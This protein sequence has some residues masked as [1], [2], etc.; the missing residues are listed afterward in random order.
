M[1]VH[2]WDPQS[3][4]ELSETAL[5]R[6]LE[7]QGYSVTRYVYPPGTHFPEHTHGVDKIDAVV[8]GRFE[9]IVAGTRHLL[10][11]GDWIT[12][13]RGV[14]HTATVVGDAPVVSL[15]AVKSG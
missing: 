5:S 14:A 13:P 10:G 8:A 9:L 2:H 15:D 12:V 6:K 11:P 7:A 4:G 3:D 1:S